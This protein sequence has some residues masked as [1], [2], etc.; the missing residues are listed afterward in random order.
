MRLRTADLSW[1]EI[2]GELV[3][4]DLRSST[5]L[6]SNA[7]GSVLI[8]HLVEDRTAGELARALVDAFGIPSSQ[9]EQDA[10]DFLAELDRAGM[11]EDS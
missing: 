9:A 11:L 2:D 7:S 6:T 10:E 3:L 4:L 1:R 8:R 5:Y